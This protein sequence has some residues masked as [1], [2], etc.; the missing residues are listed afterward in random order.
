MPLPYRK[1]KYYEMD[2]T[3]R[4]IAIIAYMERPTQRDIHT[5]KCVAQV[6]MGIERYQADAQGMTQ[7]Q[8]KAEAHQSQRLGEYMSL[9]GDRKP[10]KLCD[11]HAIVSGAHPEAAPARVVLAR[12]KIRK[13]DPVNGAWLPRNTKAKPHMPA[14]LRFA[15]PHSRIHRWEYYQWVNRMLSP[16]FLKD[17]KYLRMELSIIECK[18]QTST[19]DPRVMKYKGEK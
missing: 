7:A 4:A 5:V 15:V 16:L 6:Q 9:S 12:H 11:A 10:H 2:A 19:F 8:L 13:D 3:E 17:I 1:T 18:L 14:W